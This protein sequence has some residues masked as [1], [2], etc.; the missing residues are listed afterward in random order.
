MEL[1]ARQAQCE[2]A[3]AKGFEAV[4]PITMHKIAHL[5]IHIGKLRK[6][7]MRPF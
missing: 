6:L 3:R 5:I 4:F 1:I 7:K 2:R